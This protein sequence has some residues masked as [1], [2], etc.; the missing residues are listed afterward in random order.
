MSKLYP[1]GIYPEGEIQLYKDECVLILFFFFYGFCKNTNLYETAMRGAP[2]QKK[3]GMK[4]VWQTKIQRP[5]IKAFDELPRF[6]GWYGNMH[7]N[8]FALG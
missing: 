3:N 1:D 6:I 5:P 7:G 8:I 4:N 2:R